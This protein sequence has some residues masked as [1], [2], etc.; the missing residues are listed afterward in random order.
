MENTRFTLPL[1]PTPGRLTT[2]YAVDGGAARNAVLTTMASLLADRAGACSPVLMI[3]WDTESPGLHQPCGRNGRPASAAQAGLLEYVAACREQL[4]LLADAGD[5]PAGKASGRPS[6]EAE[7]RRARQVCEA[8]DWEPFVERVDDSRPLYLM[9]AG[10][11]DDSYGERADGVDWEGLFAASPSLYRCIAEH[12]ERRFAHILVASR[13]GRSAAVSVCTS[14]LADR[15]V[16]L[17]SPSRRSLDGACGVVR[18]AIDYRSS[19]EEAQRPLLVYPLPVDLDGADQGRRLRWRHGDAASEGSDGSGYQAVLE[20]LMRDSYGL[21]SLSLD[22]YFDHVQLQQLNA[23]ADPV[24]PRLPL[25]A[26]RL[27]L[28]RAV[29]ELLD[30]VADGG[31]PWQ[32][33]AELA[34][35]RRI[36]Q[37][38]ASDPDAVSPAAQTGL[39]ADLFELGRLQLQQGRQRQALASV[40][41]A[42]TVQAGLWGAGH[43]DTRSGRLALA[44]QLRQCGQADAAVSAYRRLFDESVQALGAG[45]ADSLAARA[46]LAAA[47]ADSGQI[48]SALSHAEQVVLAWRERGGLNHRA[49]LE[50]QAAHATVLAQ[51]GQLGRARMVLEQVLE[52]R[53][54]VLGREHAAT[55]A[56]LAQLALVLRQMGHLDS[57]RALQEQLL[58]CR[59]RLLGVDHGDT[60]EAGL[61]LADTVAAQCDLQRVGELCGP[62][63]DA[64]QRRYGCSLPPSRSAEL[65]LASVL[66]QGAGV[67]EPPLTA[68]GRPA[69]SA[70]AATA[71]IISAPHE[72]GFPP[73]AP[74]RSMVLGAASMRSSTPSSALG[75]TLSSTRHADP[76]DIERSVIHLEQMDDLSVAEA[77]ELADRLCESVL[78][79]PV[80][81]Q[82]RARG[83]RAILEVYFYQ[84]DTDALVAFMQGE[85]SAKAVKP[86]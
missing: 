71:T 2:V 64:C 60:I 8:V 11:F 54:R 6:A 48:D 70:F 59:R 52:G 23:M 14:L 53:E 7:W 72:S 31:L 12:L 75:R 10:C 62:L 74:P 5:A 42:A 55:L 33:R 51:A 43:A 86:Q 17:F 46:G 27:S 30:W 40:S 85:L 79:A 73:F 18:R 34:V 56:S 20:Q 82:L 1:L 21:P 29:A 9:R 77:R 25:T 13:G 84:G 28:A 32:A 69:A 61:A 63:A 37:A 78:T 65:T 57:A 41:E 67:S 38:R 68:A 16:M 47:L 50:A 19:H 80:A 24:V 3:D 35:G 15:L 36:A 76:D 44:F 66:A 45:H 4:A 58:A 83:V 22:N 26:D 39:A 49:T 81:P